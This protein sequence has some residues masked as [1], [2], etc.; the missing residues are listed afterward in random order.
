MRMFS[1]STNP[2]SYELSVG[3]SEVKSIPVRMNSRQPKPITGNA[4]GLAI[5]EAAA[6]LYSKTLSSADIT[7]PPCVSRDLLA[8]IG[9]E[10]IRIGETAHLIEVDDGMIRLIRAQSWDVLGNDRPESWR[11]RLT[12][13]GPTSSRTVLVPASRVIHQRWAESHEQPW[14]G[15]SP[16]QLASLDASTAWHITTA[17]GTAAAGSLGNILNMQLPTKTDFSDTELKDLAENYQQKFEQLDGQTHF[18]ITSEAPVAQIAELHGILDQALA[19]YGESRELKLLAA[20]GLPASLMTASNS[21]AQREALRHFIH[22][23]LWPLSQL[24]AAELEQKL[25]QPVRFEFPQLAEAELTNKG[26]A[27]AQLVRGGMSV[28]HA[29]QICGLEPDPTATSK[30]AQTARNGRLQNNEI[31]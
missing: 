8:Y 22:A 17:A 4:T 26:R 7:A 3:A 10:L 12:L 18:M 25:E 19:S 28:N 11:Y 15:V 20:M 16:L 31:A 23:S 6:S 14:Q 9:R 5:V 29:A 30:P 2:S 1:R 27:F 13:R 24:I 21:A